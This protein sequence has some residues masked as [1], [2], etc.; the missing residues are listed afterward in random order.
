MLSPLLFVI[1]VNRKDENVQGMA[2]K[3]AY[4]NKISGIMD[5]EGNQ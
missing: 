4:N 3:F 2:S 5:S 1:Y